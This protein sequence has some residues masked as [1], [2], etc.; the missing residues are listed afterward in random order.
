MLHFNDQLKELYEKKA[1]KTY[2]ENVLKELYLQQDELVPKVAE[3]AEIKMDEQ[4]DVERLEGGSLAAFFYGVIGKMDEK[5]DKERQEAYAASVKY[6]AAVRELEVTE[7]EIQKNENELKQLEGCEELYEKLLREKEAAIKTTIGEEAEKVLHME[8]KIAGIEGQLKEIQEAIAAGRKCHE[9]AKQVQ[10]ELNSAEDWAT[11]DM[12]GGGGVVTHM[13]KYNHL[14]N[15]QRQITRLQLQLRSF[16]TELADVHIY[17]NVQIV[18][19]GFTKFADYF[20][21]NLFVDWQIK[22]QI[23]RAKQSVN[24]LVC[25]IGEV[26]ERLEKMKQIQENEKIWL[27]KKLEE[28][29]VKTEV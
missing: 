26:L 23:G 17:A 18:I 13:I 9:V 15:A 14:D 20:F 1:R 4:E 10:K 16:K 2:L 19:N 24:L 11:W 12:F 28:M 25:Q 21:D 22:D 8:E 6:D 7:Y 27:G 3:L 5:L 29:I